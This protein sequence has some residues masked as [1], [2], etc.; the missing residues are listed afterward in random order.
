MFDL[1]YY[2]KQAHVKVCCLIQK[3]NRVDVKE[4]FEKIS[5]I[6]SPLVDKQ[7]LTWHVL[8]SFIFDNY[9]KVLLFRGKNGDFFG[10]VPTP[11]QYV[12]R[13]EITLFCVT[14]IDGIQSHLGEN[15]QIIIAYPTL[16]TSE[17][18]E[19]LIMV[20]IRSLPLNSA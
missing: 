1:I 15:D 5:A 9:R 7:Y 10:Q 11:Y 12:I 8:E 18:S 20:M 14:N 19:F 2:A 16:K 17:S 4:Q 3:K 6:L 13:K